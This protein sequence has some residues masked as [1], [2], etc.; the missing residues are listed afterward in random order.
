[1]EIPPK[2]RHAFGASGLHG[3]FAHRK[4]WR[5]WGDRSEACRVYL[6]YGWRVVLATRVEFVADLHMKDDDIDGRGIL[7]NLIRCLTPEELSDLI[8]MSIA[9]GAILR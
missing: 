7:L 6:F 1:M 3:R 5:A 9:L 2:R 4:M 8:L